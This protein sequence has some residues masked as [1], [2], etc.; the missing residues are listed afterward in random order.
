MSC[1]APSLR[2]DSVRE[3]FYEHVHHRIVVSVLQVEKTNVRSVACSESQDGG[4]RIDDIH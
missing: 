2:A 1:H 4:L 3:E